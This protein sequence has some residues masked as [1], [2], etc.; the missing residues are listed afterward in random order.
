MDMNAPTNPPS[1]QDATAQL[2]SANATPASNESSD[3]GTKKTGVGIHNWKPFLELVAA[4]A[5]VAAILFG[6]RSWVEGYVDKAVEKKLTDTVVLRKIAEQSQPM[7][8]FDENGGII[9]ESGGSAYIEKVDVYHNPGETAPWKITIKPKV[10]LQQ[11]PLLSTID[12]VLMEYTTERGNGF[13]WSYIVS[14]IVYQNGQIGMKH[15]RFR[16][17]V[18]R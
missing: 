2:K 13:E 16:L 14:G 6:I 11:P 15:W 1:Q 5:T 12:N 3:G 10:L 4:I 8:I 9:S 17:E 7:L 18:L